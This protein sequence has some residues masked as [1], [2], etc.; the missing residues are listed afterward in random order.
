[1]IIPIDIHSSVPGNN[2][3][4]LTTGEI[5][6]PMC[7]TSATV[8]CLSERNFIYYIIN[9]YNIQSTHVLSV[10]DYHGQQLCHTN[11]T[12]CATVNSSVVPIVPFVPQST[13]LSYQLYRLCHSQQLCRTNCTV[14]ATVNSSVVPIVPFVP[15]STA[16][17]YQL[18]RLCHTSCV[19]EPAFKGYERLFQDP[20]LQQKSEF[21]RNGS[22]L[23]QITCAWPQ[24]TF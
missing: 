1:M 16:L 14:C 10:S 15:Q 6:L 24:C 4:R 13:A 8:R 5:S 2:M 19:K 18:Y 12:V 11:C 22:V 7:A 20:R 17:S 3:T 9:A 23:I 21:I